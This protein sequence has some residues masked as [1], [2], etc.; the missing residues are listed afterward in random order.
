MAGLLD[1]FRVRL[2]ALPPNVR[3][4]LSAAVVIAAVVVVGGA[5]RDD[6]PRDIALRIQLGDWGGRAVE[7][8][9]VSF[10]RRGEVLRVVALRPGGGASGA[11]SVVQGEVSLPE[12]PFD[13]EVEVVCEGRVETVRRRVVVRPGEALE[14]AAGPRP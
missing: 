11:P 7:V 4:L 10:L 9:R 13:T 8:V 6:A 12:G 1:S 14:V 3:K 2:R 5:L